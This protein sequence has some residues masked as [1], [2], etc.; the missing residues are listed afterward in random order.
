ME[1]LEDTLVTR[2]TENGLHNFKPF[3]HCGGPY[4]PCD[5]EYLGSSYNLL[6]EWEVGE[7]TWEPVG[8]IIADDPYSFTVYA[9]K[10]DLL[11]TQ[12]SEKI[13]QISKEPHQNSEE[14]QV[15]TG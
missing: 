1:Y 9:K 8:N 7:V 3:Q 2:Q 15:L 6:V 11:S 13:Y 12:G 5:T 10:F 14:I 4:S